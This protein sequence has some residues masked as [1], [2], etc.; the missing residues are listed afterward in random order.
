[1]NPSDTDR[2]MVLVEDALRSV[3]LAPVPGTLR[4]GVM[5]RVRLLS[6][7]PK[8][9]FPW[10]EAAISLMLSTLLTGAATLVLGLPAATLL[11]LQQTLRLFFRL[12]A[13]R[14][15]I[16]GVLIGVG[17]LAVCLVLS[18]RIFLIRNRRAVRIVAMR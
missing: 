6:A 2:S 9:A 11:R 15:L 4:S 1:M 18:A 14:P 3:P 17:M 12:P 5:R 16:A 10:L 13:N 8:F 7:A